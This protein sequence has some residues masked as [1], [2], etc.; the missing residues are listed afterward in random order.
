M[1]L[2]W[3]KI[4][5]LWNTD[6]VVVLL[7]YSL[8]VIGV[9]CPDRVDGRIVSMLGKYSYAIFLTHHVIQA[10]Y[11]EMF[12]TTITKVTVIPIIILLS[13]ITLLVSILATKINTLVIDC[14]ARCG[15][16]MKKK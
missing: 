9:H 12:S 3:I 5:L 13:S 11:F 7:G 2:L 10:F 14:F 15:Q 8:F 6:I 4:P 1:I 16:R